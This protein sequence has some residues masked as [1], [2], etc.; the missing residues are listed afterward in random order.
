MLANT[1]SMKKVP[2]SILFE[3]DPLI[4]LEFDEAH[5]MTER[6]STEWSNLSEFRHALWSL[7]EL[8]L[9]SLFLS[10]TGKINQFVPSPEMDYSRRII[11]RLLRLFQPLTDLGFDQLAKKITLDG[12]LT[13][14]DI[15]S[16]D[17]IAHLGRPMYVLRAQF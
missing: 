17:Y 9:F 4:I 1:R 6:T 10:T 13:L 2:E 14:D 5:T 3:D 11:P 8:S 7:K 16:D 15:T 12:D